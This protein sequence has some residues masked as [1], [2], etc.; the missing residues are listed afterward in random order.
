M[1]RRYAAGL[2]D[3]AA[4]G[5]L[6][7]ATRRRL[8]EVVAA[9]GPLSREQ[10]AAQVGISR[11]LAAYHLDKLTEHG[12]LEVERRRLRGRTGP[13]AGRPAK[14]YRRAVREFVLRTP[15]RDYE[16]LG[17]LLV[18][19]ASADERARSALERAAGEVGEALAA[20]RDDAVDVLRD[21]GYEPSTETGGD[22]SLR[23]CPFDAVAQQCPDV[24][25][26]INLALVRGI[27]RGADDD[28][29]RARLAPHVGRCCVEIAHR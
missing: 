6:G 25:C 24:V 12:L 1:G 20:G 10:A 17:E 14:L 19:A 3:L 4:L 7:D 5:S 22:V 15:P 8:Y 26:S 28:P 2:T 13:G 23:N 18:R 9:D 27:L 29:E 21:R 16:L 11:A